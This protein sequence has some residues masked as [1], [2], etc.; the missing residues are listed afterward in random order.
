MNKFY[1]NIILASTLIAGA[2]HA[3]KVA[4]ETGITVFQALKELS[5]DTKL[6]ILSVGKLK[7]LVSKPEIAKTLQEF[8]AIIDML[9]RKA[10]AEARTHNK[11]VD[12]LA[13]K[14]KMVLALYAALYKMAEQEVDEEGSEE[15]EIIF[16]QQLTPEQIAEL[17]ATE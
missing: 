9:Y 16:A 12:E 5:L 13:F 3:E 15:Q 4:V 17:F 11:T 6:T 8:E 7:M 10:L 1:A 2:L 14:Q